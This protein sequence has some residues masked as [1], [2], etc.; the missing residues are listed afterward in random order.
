MT[1]GSPFA[2]IN[3]FSWL[4]WT[5]SWSRFCSVEKVKLRTASVDMIRRLLRR[6]TTDNA[7]LHMRILSTHVGGSLQHPLLLLNLMKRSSR[8]IRQ[9]DGSQRFRH[10]HLL[11]DLRK[12]SSQIIRPNLAISSLAVASHAESK[13]AFIVFGRRVL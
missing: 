10:L 11:L 2:R 1:T 9:I 13:E 12:R 7:E 5:C 8:R 6:E 3:V 4:F